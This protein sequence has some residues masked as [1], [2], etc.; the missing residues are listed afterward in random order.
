MRLKKMKQKFIF[1]FILFFAKVGISQ[2][3]LTLSINDA[4][5]HAFEHNKM[6]QNANLDVQKS[7]MAI[8][9]AISAGLPQINADA[10]YNNFLGA[11]MSIKF[12]EAMP[13]QEIEFKPQS[14]FNL[15]VSQLIFSGQYW[16]GVK[17]SKLAKKLTVMNTEKSKLDIVLQTSE[18]Y[19]LA[20]I[21]KALLKRMKLN[22]ENLKHLYEKSKPMADVGVIE[23]TD[24]DQ[25]QIQL[26][27][28]FNAVKSLERQLEMSENMLRLQLGVDINT[29]L[30]LS[31][32]IEELTQA[33]DLKEI[34]NTPFEA[35]NTIEMQLM[36]QQ[37]EITSKMLTMKKAS[38]LP[39]LA[40]FYKYTYKILKPDF[41]MSP[42][43]VVGLK[44]NIPIFAGLQRHS[45][46]QQAKI[47]LQKI[48]NTKSLMNDQIST[49]EKQ[50]KYNYNN[51]LDTYENQKKNVE[52][53]RK[54][55][56]NLKQKY[57]QGLLSGLDLINA[58]NNYVKAETDLVSATM[59]LLSAKVQLKKLY[60]INNIENK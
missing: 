52:I 2:E 40:G 6:M 44:L 28:L 38:V 20:L 54:V 39:T 33:N 7:Q 31:T 43:H 13:A 11:S 41:D 29:K 57:E 56:A 35:N 24:L 30:Q 3:T 32:T 10:D 50:L 36:K 1:I 42:A 14:N 19:H 16:V 12:S 15:S 49:Q 25:L 37:E 59:K 21:S 53:A 34:L 23:T 8:R 47:D 4:C 18:A 51:A 45:Q 26:N 27:T 60:R 46:I 9:E 58:D 22:S 5:Q 55:Y 48:Q 17:A